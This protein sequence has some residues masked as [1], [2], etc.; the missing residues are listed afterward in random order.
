MLCEFCQCK[1]KG[2]ADSRIVV[3]QGN[4]LVACKDIE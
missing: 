1:L 3:V 2:F 4:R